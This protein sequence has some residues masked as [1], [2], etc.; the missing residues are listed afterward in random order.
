MALFTPLV[1]PGAKPAAQGARLLQRACDCGAKSGAKSGGSCEACSKKKLQRKAT[2]DSGGG[3]AAALSVAPQLT[4]GGARLPQ[5]LRS[6][7]GPLFGNDFGHVRVHRDATSAAAAREVGARAFTLGEHIHFG[8][9]QWRPEGRDGLHLI[10]HELSH[11]LQ[12]AQGGAGSGEG[13][14]IDNAGSALE[15]EADHAADAAL[16]GRSVRVRGAGSGQLSR[17]LLQRAPAG[18]GTASGGSD[19]QTMDRTVDENTVVHI[20]RTVTERP[21]KEERVTKATP[22]DKIPYWDK[23]ADAVGLRYTI[24]NGRVKL[25]TKAEVDYSKV[26]ESATSLLTTLQRNPTLG[27]N[28]GGVL[29]DRLDEATVS[30]SGDITLD[31]S[32]ILQASVQANSTVGTAAQQVGVKGVLKVTPGGMVFKVTAGLDYRQTPLDKTTTYK[33]EG[34]A[35]T[36]RFVLTLAYEQID[37][38]PV[39]GPSSSTGTLT[40]GIGVKL[41][42]TPLTRDARCGPTVSKDMGNNGAPVFGGGCGLSWDTQKAPAVRCYKCDCPPPL[43]EYSCTQVTKP[44]EKPVVVKEADDPTVRLSYEYNSNVPKPKADFDSGVKSIAA[45]VGNGY[46]VKHIHGYASPEGS[47]DAPAKGKGV[48]KGNIALSQRRAD[49]TL[50]RLA[51][52]VP[53]TTLPPAE[54]LGEQLGNLDG[55]GDAADKDLTAQIVALLSP[56]SAERRLEVLGVSEVILA[57]QKRRSEA[58]AQ[59]QAFIDGQTAPGLPLAQRPRWEKV[60]P[61]LRRVEVGLHHEPV[62]GVEPVKGG[63]S[64]GC[65]DVDLAYARANMPPLPPQRRIPQERCGR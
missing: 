53:G 30:A 32:G 14:E 41:P 15:R 11:T 34:Q 17:R 48:F 22:N 59:I 12:H 1:K 2:G 43:P 9:G 3:G 46:S 45:M 5:A 23:Q 29:Q 57:D 16:A 44:H 50:A 60:F 58:L 35:G 51:K 36:E 18:M 38:S 6:T 47:L 64:T 4:Q 63:T 27:G 25:S 52:E 19:T 20:R 24:C 28:L 42:D 26:V 10:A 7:L 61:F 65:N 56:L 31:V 55:S 33:L 21:C 13:V 8:A 62:M 40:G 49:H 37:F 39:G 54:G